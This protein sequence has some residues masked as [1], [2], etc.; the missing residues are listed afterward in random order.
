MRRGVLGLVLLSASGL[1]HGMGW[2]DLWSRP[3][4]QTLVRREQ[5]YTE[6]QGEQ[7]AAAAQ[8]LQS[9]SDPVSQYNRG[10]A[11][12]HTG[13]LQGAIS[14]YDAVLHDGATDAILKRDA[15]HNRDLVGQQEKSQPQSGTSGDKDGKDQ[16]NDKGG[17]DGKGAKDG[18]ASSAD[19]GQQ[20]N[21]NSDKPRGDKGQGERDQDKT[22][23]DKRNQPAGGADAQNAKQQQPPG[24]PQREQA[25]QNPSAQGGVNTANA[26]PGDVPPPSEQAQSLDQ[27]LRWIP[28]DP[29]GL[30]RRKF[31]IE[32]ML[33]QRGEQQ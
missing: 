15:Q 8:H 23:Q 6:I 28:D 31:M 18:K 2:A 25:E 32:H 11:L 7:Y 13:D 33:N 26:R 27:W 1:A 24:P 21:E 29:G 9:F 16:K 19:K 5:A 22:T 12:A 14:A 4:Q 10:N 30:L 20:N 3:E 17:A